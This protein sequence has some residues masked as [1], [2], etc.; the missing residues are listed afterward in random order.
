MKKI[1]MISLGCAKNQ[2]N[3]EQMIFLLKEAGYEISPRTEEL[4]AVVINTC[5][6]IESAKAEAIETILEFCALKTEGRLQKIFVTGCLAERYKS[7]LRVEMPEI[8][9]VLGTGSGDRIVAALDD[10]FNGNSPEWFGTPGTGLDEVK[11][12]LTTPIGWS[13]LKIAEGCDN[14]C[15][16]C[17]IPLLRGAYRSRPIQ[18]IL[19]EAAELAADGNKE[20]VIIAQDITRYGIDL[21]GERRL[22]QL[23]REIAQISG[24]EWIRLLYLYPDEITDELIDLIASEPKILKYLDIPIQHINDGVL[25]RMNRRGTGA[26][27]KMLFAELRR[28]IPG[29]V[30]RST[31]ITGLPGEGYDEFEELCA[32]LREAKIERLGA[33][34]YSPEDGTPAYDMTDRAPQELA[35]H[36]AELIGDLQADIMQTFN[37]PRI[38]TVIDVLIEGYEDWMEGW[39]GRSYAEAPDVDGKVFVYAGG[40]RFNVGDIVRV[41][42]ND[43]IAGDLVGEAV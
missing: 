26:E 27:I 8:D 38:G 22:P 30:L 41:R 14:R 17:T 39:F 7:E 24:V 16:F 6:F 20:L 23:L 37:E 9:G 4:D 34:V 43:T 25:R 28:R 21:Y 1:G 11:R 19:A 12:V 40:K 10:A 2:V 18:N 15:A 42:V 29:L 3:S 5:G 36:R 31:V 35:E 13:Y 33:F 32:F